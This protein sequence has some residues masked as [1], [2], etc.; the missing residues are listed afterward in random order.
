MD[1]F[2]GNHKDLAKVLR[3]LVHVFI[4][5]IFKIHRLLRIFLWIF[6]CFKSVSSI[7][8]LN[9]LL[10]LHLTKAVFSKTTFGSIFQS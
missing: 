5:E 2:I 10:I 4:R 6:G 1:F 3:L 9:L 7:F 8:C